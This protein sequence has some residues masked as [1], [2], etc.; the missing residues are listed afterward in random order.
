[1][2]LCVDFRK[3][4]EM[5]KKCVYPLPNMNDCVETLAGNKLFS[6][7][8]M[9]GIFWQLLSS[10]LAKELTAFRT[11]DGQFQFTRMPFGLIN[12]LASL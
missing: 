10:Q 6:Q 12:A 7:L 2:R 11:E 9:A 1:M 3:Q 8:D 4:N 5:T